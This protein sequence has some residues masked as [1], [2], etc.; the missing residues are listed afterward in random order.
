[1]KKAKCKFKQLIEDYA[2]WF[3]NHGERKERRM[4]KQK[5]V[6]QVVTSK[7]AK[8]LDDQAVALADYT[9]KVYIAADE[10]GIKKKPLKQ[11]PLNEKERATLAALPVLPPGL[12]KKLEKKAAFTVVDACSVLMAISESVVEGD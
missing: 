2:Y 10:R 4:A 3:W 12:K 5:R 6:E 1:M 7:R 9:A 8:L 11:L